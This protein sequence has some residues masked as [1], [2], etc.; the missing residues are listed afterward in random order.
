MGGFFQE[1]N[2][3]TPLARD[4]PAVL[5]PSGE[6]TT[7]PAG[8]RLRIVHTRGGDFTVATLDGFM[9][10][11]EGRDADALGLSPPEAEPAAPAADAAP[12]SLEDQ[13]WD[14]LRTCYDPEIPVNIVE[15]GLVYK[16]ELS[17][18]PDGAKRV[19]IAMTLTAPGC[20]M[21]QVL[22][23]DV[24]RKV[25]TLPGIADADVQVVFDPPWNPTMMSES[26]RLELGMY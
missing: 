26:A 24:K 1:L 19:S 5:I 15:L 9:F 8:T 22:A 14:Q 12:K 11:I 23:D 18:L 13:V 20:G 4:V 7:I 10:R 17:D 25:L 6:K 16:C 2:P 21:G 3:G